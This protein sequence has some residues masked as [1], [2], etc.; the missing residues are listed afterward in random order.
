MGGGLTNFFNKFTPPSAEEWKLTIDDA[1]G[2]LTVETGT[3]ILKFELQPAKEFGD[4]KVTA[5]RS[6][7]HITGNIFHHGLKN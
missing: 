2:M 1:K 5:T 3:R 6:A 7:R 4:K